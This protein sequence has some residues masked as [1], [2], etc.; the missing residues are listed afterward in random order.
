MVKACNPTPPSWSWFPPALWEWRRL[1]DGGVSRWYACMH[2]CKYVC[3]DG[4]MD[5]CVDAWMYGCMDV[6]MYVCMH[7]CNVM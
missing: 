5:G 2:A 1:W 6:W 7:V 4:R 3:M